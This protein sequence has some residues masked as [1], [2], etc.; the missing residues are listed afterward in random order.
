VTTHWKKLILG[1]AL[2]NLLELYNFILYGYFSIILSKLF[3]PLSNPFVS[4]MLTFSVFAMGCLMRP[5][6]ALLFGYL[7][8]R[9]GRKKSLMLSIVMMTI[10]TIL[11]GLLPT[12][13]QIGI[14]APLLLVLC[15]L[16]Q[17]LSMS[18][19]Q[20]GASIFLTENAP[21]HRAGL[22]GSIIFGS[23]YSGLLLGSIVAL[24]TISFIPEKE[25]LVWGWRIPF[26]LSLLLGAV[27]IVIRAKQGESLEFSKAKEKNQLVSQPIREVFRNYFPNILNTT[28]LCAMLAVGVYLFAVYIPSYLNITVGFGFKTSMLI[29]SFGFLC[30]SIFVV[31]VGW[32]TDRVGS[33]LPM[34][35]SCLGFIVFAY[36]IFWLLSRHTIMSALLAEFIIVIL[37]GLTAGSLMPMLMQS[38]PLQV[39]CTGVCFGFNTSMMLFG[40]TA[41]LAALSLTQ[42]LQSPHAPFLYLIVTAVITIF[43][44]IKAKTVLPI[45]RG[46][47]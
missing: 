44:T 20:I 9:L 21:P 8:D 19:E 23:V 11:I 18:G 22:A 35:L 6:G 5:L 16:L 36:P 28:F 47:I 43:A 1:C 12:Y 14:Y 33:K 30:T 41:P 24:L 29:C 38:F 40:S 32:W 37:L 2:G 25:L 46:S 42:Y 26:L 27:A 10:A 3:F 4:L 15:R 39:R 34:L 31:F 13:A 17:G 45:E 7:G